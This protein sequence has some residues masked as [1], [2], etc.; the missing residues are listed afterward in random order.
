LREAVTSSSEWARQGW[1]AYRGT[2]GEHVF[3]REFTACPK[4][5]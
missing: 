1:G 2:G 3:K 4:P 5:Q